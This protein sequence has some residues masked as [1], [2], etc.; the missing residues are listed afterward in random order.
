LVT[1]ASAGSHAQ[2]NQGAEAPPPL[3]PLRLLGVGVGGGVQD[4]AIDAGFYARRGLAVQLERFLG[5]PVV[6][7]A[8]A[9]GGKADMGEYGTPILTGVSLGLPMKIVGSPPIKGPSSEL[10]AR[11]G[12]ETVADL[13]G[14]VVA[15]GALGS[16]PHQ[17]VLWILHANGLDEKTDVNVVSSGGIDAE[18][19]LRSGRVDAVITGGL[20]RLKLIDEGHGNMIAD[21]RNY[22]G[23]HQHNYVYATDDFIK[24]H[25]QAIRAYFLATRDSLEYAKAHVDELIGYTGSRIKVRKELIRAYYAEQIPQWDLSFRIDLEGTLM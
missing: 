12:I 14:K 21:V 4:F 15:A 13:R 10:V 18:M 20:T 3:V 5:G 7:T 22:Y 2:S 1:V 11:K 19:V 23:R 17:A 24:N 9:A 25:P 16:G 8:A 6:A